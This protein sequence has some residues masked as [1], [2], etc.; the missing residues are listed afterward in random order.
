[1]TSDEP[2][3]CFV[4]GSS[5]GSTCPARV[6]PQQHRRPV[7]HVQGRGLWHMC[8]SPTSLP[9]SLAPDPQPHPQPQ[10]PSASASASPALL[11]SA[12]SPP[13]S[14]HPHPHRVRCAPRPLRG[15]RAVPAGAT[16]WPVPKL[17][18]WVHTKQAVARAVSR[19]LEWESH[20]CVHA[21]CA[22]RDPQHSAA[23]VV[24]AAHQLSR[25]AAEVAEVARR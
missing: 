2:I 12:P 14:D 6:H 13:R 17:W 21:A 20:L 9:L 11:L 10:P 16:R 18:R 25:L 23:A 22:G 5:V 24:L 7:L 15:V 3:I 8:P 4:Q 1:M 19:A